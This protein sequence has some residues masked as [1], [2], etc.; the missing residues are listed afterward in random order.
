MFFF[1]SD[2]F[3]I[4]VSV[5][6]ANNG[7]KK[8]PKSVEVMNAEGNKRVKCSHRFVT[9]SKKLKALESIWLSVRREKNVALASQ[10]M[11]E[12]VSENMSNEIA[13]ITR[14]VVQLKYSAPESTPEVLHMS[15]AC[16]PGGETTRGGR[17]L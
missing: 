12:A 5:A 11:H 16:S 14:D 10:N 13:E 3:K 7:R 8:H 17:R 15:R 4:P 2:M 1:L 6:I 9:F